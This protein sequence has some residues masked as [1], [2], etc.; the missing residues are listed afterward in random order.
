MKS[1]SLINLL[2]L[3]TLLLIATSIAGAQTAPAEANYPAWTA[4]SHRLEAN[5]L[6]PQLNR[7]A[8]VAVQEVSA[9]PDFHTPLC[10]S[11]FNF[12]SKLSATGYPYQAQIYRL[13]LLG[14]A[15]Y[16]IE[17]GK[18]DPYGTNTYAFTSVLKGY[19]SIINKDPNARDKTMDGLLLI[20]LK[21]KLPD[22]LMK[23]TTC[24]AK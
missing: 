18:T 17:T 22:M 16:R 15:T 8:E 21:G 11:F 14:S 13:Y 9:S 10:S 19:T 23:D 6:D 5:P 2:S 7:D 12:F 4:I 20:D 1:A 3:S 24:R